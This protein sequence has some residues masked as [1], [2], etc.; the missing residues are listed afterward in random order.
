MPGGGWHGSFTGRLGISCQPRVNTRLEPESTAVVRDWLARGQVVSITDGL[1]KTGVDVFFGR[2]AAADAVPKHAAEDAA[3]GP[4][5]IPVIKESIYVGCDCNGR[6][7][8]RGR[9]S[10]CP[11]LASW[12]RR[13]LVGNCGS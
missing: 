10:L 11:W 9:S 13:H 6:R 1:Y 2:G 4:R 5:T 12:D 3:A 7:V 8:G